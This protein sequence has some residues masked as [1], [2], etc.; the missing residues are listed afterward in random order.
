MK[1]MKNKWF[2]N[3]SIP[4]LRVIYNYD[5][6]DLEK[7]KEACENGSIMKARG[8]GKVMYGQIC[9]ALG[10]PMNSKNSHAICPHCKKPLKIFSEIK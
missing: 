6:Q 1:T 4:T 8:C 5:L 2:E 3:L 10:I 7:A 9:A